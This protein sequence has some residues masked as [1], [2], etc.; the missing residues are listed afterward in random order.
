MVQLQ[1][2][3]GE[4][5]GT[6]LEARRFPVR[7][8]RSDQMDLRLAES[9]VWDEHLRLALDR[10]QGIVAEPMKAALLHLNGEPSGR[11]VL[12]NGDLLEIGSARIRFWISPASQRSFQSREWLTWS[13]LVIIT[14]AQMALI[15]WLL[16]Q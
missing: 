8:G 5:A 2:L 12:K 10:K 16:R 11:T 15:L 3:S 1:I 13:G 7:I 6:I 14:L 4:K 9:G